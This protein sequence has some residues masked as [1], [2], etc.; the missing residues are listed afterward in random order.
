MRFP[1]L[2]SLWRNQTIRKF[3][4]LKCLVVNIC[5]VNFDDIANMHC[6]INKSS[7]TLNLQSDLNQVY[8]SSKSNNSLTVSN[9]KLSQMSSSYD[10]DIHD[11]ASCGVMPSSIFEISSGVCW[12]SIRQTRL[13]KSL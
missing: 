2:I 6:F 7:F 9:K 3:E 13:S 11:I 4:K 5:I 12:H 8:S 10:G 1:L